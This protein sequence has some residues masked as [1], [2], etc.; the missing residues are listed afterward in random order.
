MLI[1]YIIDMKCIQFGRL[2]TYILA[3]QYQ[4]YKHTYAEVKGRDIITSE[5]TK[6]TTPF[7]SKKVLHVSLL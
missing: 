3:D 1:L 6:S 4:I 5:E 7:T 2:I